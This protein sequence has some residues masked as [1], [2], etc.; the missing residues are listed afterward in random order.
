MC[1]SFVQYKNK[2]ALEN[3]V[4]LNCEGG[5]A[6]FL[7]FNYEQLQYS[8]VTSRKR[9]LQRINREGVIYFLSP[10][11]WVSTQHAV[12]HIR[13][14][15]GSKEMERSCNLLVGDKQSGVTVTSSLESLRQ[16]KV[17]TK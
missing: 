4:S 5:K 15:N 16:M 9:R 3:V 7:R 6:S 14:Q 13:S 17:Y 8:S 1:K 2:T 11:V 12:F 10:P